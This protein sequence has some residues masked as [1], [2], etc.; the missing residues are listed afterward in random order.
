MLEENKGAEIKFK[1]HSNK[2][3]MIGVFLVLAS[4]AGYV[5]FTSGIAADVDTLKADVATKTVELDSVKSQVD[6]ME[7]AQEVLDLSTEVKRLDSLKAIPVNMDQDDVLRD[8]VDIADDNEIELTTIGFGNG[9]NS[10]NNVGVLRVNAG[11]QGDYGDLTNF[12]EGLEQ[13]ARLFRVDSINVQVDDLDISSIKK[14]V[15][16]LSMEAYFQ[17]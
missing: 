16:S 6:Q 11:F 10:D 3:T 15:F 1:K 7:E 17:N 4:I 13:N 8:I 2:K 5:F 9:V 14:V 12:L